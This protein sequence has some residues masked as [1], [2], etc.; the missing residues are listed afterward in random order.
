MANI[1]KLR[2]AGARIVS[3]AV[4][5]LLCASVA[6]LSGPAQ[7]PQHPASA[8]KSQ[9]DQAVELLR[10]GK[11]KEADALFAKAA[12]A[13]NDPARFDAPLGQAQIAID[14]HQLSRADQLVT[15]TL[16]SHDTLPEAHNM[17]GL[18]LLLEK[19]PDGAR[20]EFNRA[21]QL[22]AKYVTPRLYLA[23][24][25][26]SVNDY[27]GAAARYQGVIDVAP[28][29]PA[30]Y[31]GEAESLTMMHREADALKVL[32]SWKSGDPKSLLPYQVI[33]NVNLSDR[34]PHDAVRQLLAALKLAPHDS[35]TLA[36]LGDAYAGAG[37]NWDATIAYQ[38]ALAS[39]RTNI[40]AAL[41]L[42]TLEAASG[43]TDSALVHFKGVLS[44]DPN[45]AVA[46]NDAAWLLA[47]QGKDLDEALRLAQNAVKRNPKYPDANDTL[48]WVLYCRGEYPAAV[49]A[50]KQ[51]KALAPANPDVA[52]HLGLAYARTGHNQEALVELNR[53]LNSG[54]GP[55][56]RPQVQQTI[57]QLSASPAG[58]SP[59]KPR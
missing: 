36:E 50:L 48:G 2:P 13:G 10:E 15:A 30:G 21:V 38:S 42:G 57:A 53:A 51:A 19:N 24:M 22:D 49:V 20:R 27:N 28:R 59:A 58:A 4:G 16:K 35:S 29:L 47:S 5:T 14:Q 55:S 41:G 34:K 45:N 37:D 12:A 1:E 44:I 31:L 26:R 18:V 39:D 43:K 56:L 54:N 8:G 32:E 23:A 6:V 33:A 3:L 25:A 52:A 40:K 11:L 46:S 17:K 7:T 9:M